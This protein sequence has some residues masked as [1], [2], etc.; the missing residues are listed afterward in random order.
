MESTNDPR[1]AKNHKQTGIFVDEL[2]GLFA[3]IHQV[4]ETIFD[5]EEGPNGVPSE[6]KAAWRAGFQDIEDINIAAARARNDSLRPLYKRVVVQALRSMA[7]AVEE[8][9]A[10]DKQLSSVMQ[11][12]CNDLE[13]IQSDVITRDAE[14]TR[15]REEK[16]KIEAALTTERLTN[17]AE[18]H[19]FDT[20]VCRHN[21]GSIAEGVFIDKGRVFMCGGEVGQI[22]E[23]VHIPRFYIVEPSS[24]SRPAVWLDFK[25]AQRNFDPHSPTNKPGDMVW[26]FS[27]MINDQAFYGYGLL[28]RVEE[29]MNIHWIVQ[30]SEAKKKSL[31][32]DIKDEEADDSLTNEHIEDPEEEVSASISSEPD[33]DSDWE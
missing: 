27:E 15:L 5:A 3:D 18:T 22:R 13:R 9:V 20:K 14:L 4:K 25:R 7:A 19:C 21:V 17:P 32:Y 16:R 2:E 26:G 10:K 23:T 33:W 1:L 11:K 6:V 28:G 12:V 24:R 29:N 30:I 8:A 31:G